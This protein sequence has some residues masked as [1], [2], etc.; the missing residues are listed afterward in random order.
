MTYTQSYS[1]TITPGSREVCLSLVVSAWSP[2]DGLIRKCL[3]TVWAP[4]PN[5]PRSGRELLTEGVA[6]AADS[7][8]IQD[9]LF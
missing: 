3:K 7:L 4:W 5:W 1:I 8:A 6:L 2:R 9:P